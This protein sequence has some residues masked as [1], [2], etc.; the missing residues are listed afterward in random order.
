MF[1]DFFFELRRRKV[2]V[3]THEWLA[4]MR[5]LTLGLHDS[6]LDGFYQL[7]RSLLVKDLAHYD[8]FD[9][10]FVAVFRGVEG[11][12]LKLLGELE[13]DLA[14][15][16][17]DPRNRKLLDAA[18][19]EALQKLSFDELRKLFEERLREQKERHDGGN[20]WIGTGGTSP[21]GNSGQHPTGLRLGQGGGRSAMRVAEQRR[22]RAYRSDEVL[23]VRKIDVALRLLREL[24]REGAPDELD[25]DET[26]ARTAKNAGDLEVVLHPPRRNRAKLLLLMDVGGSMDPHARLASQL[27]TAASRA[28]RFARFRSY[29]F[30]NCVYDAVYQDAWFREPVTVAELLR[31]SDRDEKLVIVGDAAMHPM[32]LLAP[33]GSSYY[34]GWNRSRAAG[35]DWMCMVAEH[36]RRRAWLNPDPESH[37]GSETV[38]VLQRLFPMYPLTLEG[39]EHAVKH[40]VRGGAHVSA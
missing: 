6:T 35:I 21:F 1:L 4:L 16:L 5:A 12:S 15:W 13:R 27:F 34:Y 3:S 18:E 24:G 14:D 23:D 2:P 7:A 40:L 37:W 31:K 39:L 10:A 25:L 17:S 28:G 36:F 9:Q 22:Y 33:G 8:A 26:I 11:E 29:Y 20:K 38:Q 30:H 32:E 19:L